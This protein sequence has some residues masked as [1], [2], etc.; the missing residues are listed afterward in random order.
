MDFVYNG[1]SR[2]RRNCTGIENYRY[3]LA[4]YSGLYQYS[5]YQGYEK[6]TYELFM[7]VNSECDCAFEHIYAFL[8]NF[9]HK[10]CANIL[11]ARSLLRTGAQNRYSQHEEDSKG[12]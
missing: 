11:H 12:Q 1:T 7:H 5:R 9:P 3:K 10:S 4:G 6:D 2:D 8:W